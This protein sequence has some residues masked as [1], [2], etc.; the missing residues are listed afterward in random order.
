MKFAR[1]DRFQKYVFYI[2]I[3]RSRGKAGDTSFKRMAGATQEESQKSQTGEGHKCHSDISKYIRHKSSFLEKASL[4]KTRIS[5]CQQ[6]FSLV[7]VLKQTSQSYLTDH[8]KKNLNKKNDILYPSFLHHSHIQNI[9]D[10]W[11]PNKTCSPNTN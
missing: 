4:A 9:S 7:I 10:K 11:L 6:D 1:Q 8:F 2:Y 3:E 5:Y